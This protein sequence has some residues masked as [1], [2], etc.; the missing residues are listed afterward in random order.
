MREEC[1]CLAEELLARSGMRGEELGALNRDV[2]T[3]WNA[4]REARD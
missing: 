2:K 1:G 3:L 4:L